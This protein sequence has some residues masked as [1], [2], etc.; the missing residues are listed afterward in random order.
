MKIGVECSRPCGIQLKNTK[1]QNFHFSQLG[2]RFSQNIG[3]CKCRICRIQ[4]HIR[5]FVFSKKILKKFSK[6]YF[7]VYVEFY[8]C[9]SIVLLC[10][11][12][13]IFFV[14]LHRDI[15]YFLL[16]HNTRYLV[17]RDFSWTLGI[18]SELKDKLLPYARIYIYIKFLPCA[19]ILKN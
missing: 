12:F 7:H 15:K 2:H 13:F 18:G 10:F 9:L 17:V 1:L 11:I 16:L 19:F 6:F 14:F 3:N 4:I 8:K 5:I